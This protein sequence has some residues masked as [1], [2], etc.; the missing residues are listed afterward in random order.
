[1]PQARRLCCHGG[2]VVFLA[3]EDI[4]IF[5]ARMSFHIPN[6]EAILNLYDS[7]ARS[8]A[9]QVFGYRFPIWS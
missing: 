1:M 3:S 6:R 9:F 4:F 7:I 8:G 2:K 5:Q